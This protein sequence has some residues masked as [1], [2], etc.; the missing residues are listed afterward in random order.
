[1]NEISK[2][3]HHNKKIENE[4]RKNQDSNQVFHIKM[5]QKHTSI[6]E[7]NRILSKIHYRL[8]Q[9]YCITY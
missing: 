3:Y 1:M 2:I 6:S 7:I 4:F 5:C 8:H 9:H